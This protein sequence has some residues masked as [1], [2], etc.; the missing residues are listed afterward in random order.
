MLIKVHEFK[1]RHDRDLSGYSQHP[2]SGAYENHL[3]IVPL[4]LWIG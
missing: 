2:D 4:L 3:I 1:A